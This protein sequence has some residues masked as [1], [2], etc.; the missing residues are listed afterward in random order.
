MKKLIL[1][2]VIICS[3]GVNSLSAQEFNI[4]AH[5]GVPVG[6]IKDGSNFA[7]G[8]DLSYLWSAADI[9]KIGPKVGYH[10]FFA[11]ADGVDNLSFLPIAAEGRVSLGG[12]VFVGAD[13]GYGLGISDGNDGGFYYAPKLGFGFL[14]LDVIGSYTAVSMDGGTASSVNVGLEFGF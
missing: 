7:L 11:E 12:M 1:A 6:D 9:L 5:V 14:G 8:A 10:T 4:G 2:A 13:L 3:F